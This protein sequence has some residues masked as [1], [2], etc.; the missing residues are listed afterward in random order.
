MNPNSKKEPNDI[1][2]GYRTRIAN[3]ISYAEKLLKENNF[4]TLNFSAVGGSI[5]TLV[6]AVEILKYSNPG[7]YQ[8]NR[9][10][11][12]SYQSV[13]DTG[14]IEKQ[15]LYPKLEIILTLEKP[16]NQT[17][18]YQDPLSEEDRKKFNDIRNKA[19]D[20]I[21]NRRNKNRNFDGRR[22]DQRGFRGGFRG[23]RR[24]IRGR[25]ILSISVTF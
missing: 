25:G 13:E 11:T 7:L 14:N 10:A 4:K 20:N 23:P 18:G 12:I 9:M 2:V 6:S 8:I 5:G 1:R 17:E 16:A 3:V 15:R 19:K 22:K 24:G 21:R